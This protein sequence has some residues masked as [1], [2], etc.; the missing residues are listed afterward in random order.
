MTRR[1]ALLAAALAA[2]LASPGLWAADAA[3]AA[4]AAPR[5]LS[6]EEAVAS[7]LAVDP[8]VLSASLD[9][10]A[11]QARAADA[12]Y[13]MLPS[14]ALS[15]GYTQLS[16]EPSGSTAGID[17]AYA[18]LVDNLLKLFSG[19][20]S[21]SR[22]V[23]L[24]LQYPVFAGFRLREAAE[25][26]RLQSLGKE[27]AA[28]LA[29]RALS[30]EI[31]RAYWE[32]E[33][34]S[35]NVET[36]G[37]AFELEGVLRDETSSL[38]AQ[39][40]ASEADRLAEEA[41][42]DQATLALDDAKA[43]RELSLLVLSSLIGDSSARSVAPADYRLSSVPGAGIVPPELSDAALAEPGAGALLEEALARRPETRAASIAM[44]ASA[45][46]KI[47]A[48][49]DL[50]PTLSLTG[51]LS[52]ADPDPRLFPPVDKFNLTWSVGARLR[53]DIGSLPGALERGKAA[54]AD[55]AKAR[56][57]LD[58]QRNAI[59][60]DLRRCVLAL[61][62]SRNSL[63]LTKGM[64]AQAEEAARVADLKYQNGMAKRSD[65]L[66]AQ[67]ALLRARLAVENKSLDV[68]IAQADLLRAGALDQ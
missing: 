2:A 58:R 23:R 26:A 47:A 4:S 55:L 54:E 21:N 36:L 66:Q 22:D 53:Y 34:A 11:T 56:S 63:V 67:M 51:G 38:A 8:G 15:A 43:G 19:A 39:G 14:L 37:K 57:D 40:M 12:R 44:R 32:S 1:A 10:R 18:P 17:P 59:A 64:V 5:S 52:Y 29:K 33:R 3:V 20:P 61:R 28:E 25:I 41:R 46:A 6:V 30:F 65:L 62:R 45:A 60:L 16:V 13:R 50:Y 68:E 49:A 27:S 42:F 31:R 9:L 48:K 7:G 35:S 24:D